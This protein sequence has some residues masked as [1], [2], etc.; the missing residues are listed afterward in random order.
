MDDFLP[1]RLCNFDIDIKVC[2]KF[3]FQQ[4]DTMSQLYTEFEI[5][6]PDS[7]NFYQEVLQVFNLDLG[8]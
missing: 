7:T 2:S 4:T 1:L 6:L 3:G 5:M 8:N